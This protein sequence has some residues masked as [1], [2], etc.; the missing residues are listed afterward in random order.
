MWKKWFWVP[1]AWGVELYSLHG[2]GF[3]RLVASNWTHSGSRERGTLPR[4]ASDSWDN[5]GERPAT[6]TEKAR[7]IKQQL[8]PQVDC[9]PP[10]S[11]SRVW[12]QLEGRTESECSF[13]WAKQSEN[14]PPHAP[15]CSGVLGL[16]LKGKFQTIFL[17]RLRNFTPCSSMI[18]YVYTFP[19]GRGKKMKPCFVEL[20]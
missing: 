14:R 5:L 20:G 8:A 2:C 3:V 19:K 9:D 10:H 4:L 11:P 18:T 16:F 12:E 1:A 17:Q 7:A 13:Y 15:V 6:L